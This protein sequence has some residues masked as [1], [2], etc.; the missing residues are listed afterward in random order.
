MFLGD[1]MGAAASA[2]RFSKLADQLIASTPQL[3][4]ISTFEA[5]T[6]NNFPLLAKQDFI[7]KLIEC[8]GETKAKISVH[9]SKEDVR[10]IQLSTGPTRS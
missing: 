10:Q 2:S 3:L 7:K 6:R 5:M 4:D 8:V 1:S 9:Y